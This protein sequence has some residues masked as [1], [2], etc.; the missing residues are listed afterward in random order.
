VR[1]TPAFAVSAIDRRTT[2]HPGYAV[3]H[4]VLVEGM[5]RETKRHLLSAAIATAHPGLNL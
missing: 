4:P 5:W 3:L 2:D 1:R